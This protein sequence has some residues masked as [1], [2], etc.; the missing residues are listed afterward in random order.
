MKVLNLED[1]IQ[2]ALEERKYL[3]DDNDGYQFF[4]EAT[5]YDDKLDNRDIAKIVE[6]DDPEE[7]FYYMLDTAWSDAVEDEYYSLFSD[8][9]QDLRRAGVDA[10]GL[11]D[12]VEEYV[13]EHL[14]INAPYAHYR[15]QMVNVNILMDTGDANYDY[16]INAKIPFVKETGLAWLAS[17]QGYSLEQLNDAMERG[18]DGVQSA[19][20]RSVWTEYTECP[21]S[22]PTVCF[23][24]RMTL[25]N[26]MDLNRLIKA[27]DR[28]GICYDATKKPD[29]GTFHIGKETMTGLFDFMTGGGSVLEIELEKDVDIPI[30][31]VRS[32]TPDVND[33][34]GIKWSIGDVYGMCGSAWKETAGEIQ[35]PKG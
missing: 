24:V 7:E 2:K 18:E 12:K 28:N 20:L 32:A 31:F 4:M 13:R 9:E 6:A 15:K 27:Q 26:L 29:C 5:S 1:M 21:S 10:E 35:E 30:K 22:T 34:Q 19:F 11:R 3:F 8:I 14:T 17:T 16:S 25:G 23:L 33:C